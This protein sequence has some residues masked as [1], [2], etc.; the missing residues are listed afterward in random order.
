MSEPSFSNGERW[1]D[2]NPATD[3]KPR[4]LKY[5]SRAIDAYCQFSRGSIFVFCGKVSP[6][7][8]NLYE[9]ETPTFGLVWSTC[10]DLNYMEPIE[11]SINTDNQE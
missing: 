4:Y 1:R 3:K 9:I 2:W 5:K 8:Q 6:F 7:G 10:E 11:E